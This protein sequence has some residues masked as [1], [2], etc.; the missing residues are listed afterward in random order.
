MRVCRAPRLQSL[1]AQVGMVGITPRE[2]SLVALGALAAWEGAA[3]GTAQAHGL[4]PQHVR[5]ALRRWLESHDSRVRAA[6]CCIC[7][8]E[9]ACLYTLLHC[10][11]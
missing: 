9:I 7:L 5:E 8:C 4:Q 2:L 11:Y 1:L 6:C 10:M 3:A